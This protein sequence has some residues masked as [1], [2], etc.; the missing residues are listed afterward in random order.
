MER[1]YHCCATCRHFQVV[2]QPGQKTSYRCAR[3]GYETRPVYQFNCWNPKEI[4]SERMK[5]E[6]KSE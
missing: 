5:Q 6:K 3:L 1:K 2:K 4:V